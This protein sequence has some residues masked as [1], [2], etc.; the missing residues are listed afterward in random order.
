MLQTLEMHGFRGFE[1]YRLSNL[2]RVNLL[3][4]KN[5]CGKS[6]VLEAIELLVSGGNPAVF[7]RSLQRR[8]DTGVRY[9]AKPREWPVDVSH[10]FFGHSCTPG[11]RFELSSDSPHGRHAL[12]VRIVPLDDIREQVADW[13]QDVGEMLLPSTLDPHKFAPDEQVAPMFGMWIEREAPSDSD[14]P[15]MPILLPV[16]EDGEILVGRRHRWMRNAT[17]GTPIRFLTLESIEPASLGGIWDTIVVEG[18][19]AEIVNDMKLLQPD[20]DSIHFLTMSRLGRGVLVGTQGGRRLPISIYGDGMRR[21]L[22]L[23]LS[24]EGTANGVLLID[25]IDTGL[26]WTVMEDM[27]QVVVEVARNLNVQVFAT[28][29]SLDCIGGLGALLQSRPDLDDEV[30]IQKIHGSL[31]QAAC[32]RGEHIRVAVEQDIEVR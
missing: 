22:A 25:E 30:S 27:W 10:V 6:S 29:H 15:F 13:D 19:E 31:E 16:M 23:R 7:L 4:G 8:G 18:R 5:N 21:L 3:V 2:A 24:F 1:S 28:T 32:L 17:L 12:T 14:E 20:L 11:A 9:P 26:H